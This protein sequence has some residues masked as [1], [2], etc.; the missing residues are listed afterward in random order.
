VLGEEKSY[1]PEQRF[2]IECLINGKNVFAA[3][4]TGFGKTAVILGPEVV[5]ALM[6]NYGVSLV[7]V[8]TVSLMRHMEGKLAKD[9][10]GLAIV[11]V[12]LG[13]DKKI[14]LLQHVL[15]KKAEKNYLVLCSFELF[16]G[17][18]ADLVRAVCPILRITFDEVHQ[19]MEWKD[20]FR[21]CA[22]FEL[23]L[24]HFPSLPC[25]LCSATAP[26]ELRK[27]ICSFL[28]RELVEFQEILH[29]SVRR[30]I[31]FRVVEQTALYCEWPQM[32]GFPL[33]VIVNSFS[34]KVQVRQFLQRALGGESE[35]RDYSGQMPPAE[36]EANQA[37][38]EAN[39]CSGVLIST[40]G[41][42]GTGIDNRRLCHL[43]I[44]GWPR[45]WSALHQYM[46]RVGRQGQNARVFLV[47]KPQDFTKMDT[48]LRVM[49]GRERAVE[50]EA[51]KAR[52]KGPE[53]L[54]TRCT[55]CA[56]HV[57][58]PKKVDGSW[59]RF[60]PEKGGLGEPFVCGAVGWSCSRNC[61][62]RFCI[63]SALV[64]LANDKSPG[65]PLYSNDDCGCNFC[66]PAD[67]A[68]VFRVGDFVQITAWR[69]EYLLQKGVVV[70]CD[71][72]QERFK[73]NFGKGI[74]EKFGG[75]SLVKLAVPVAIPSP[76]PL[77]EDSG[78]PRELHQSLVELRARL[79]LETLELVSLVAS[80]RCLKML[81]RY[82]PQTVAALVDL[83]ALVQIH[84]RFHSAFVNAVLQHQQRKATRV[85]K[86]SKPEKGGRTVDVQLG[87]ESPME[88]PIRK[89]ST[90]TRTPTAKSKAALDFSA[91]FSPV[92]VNTSPIQKGLKSKSK[93]DFSKD[94][95]KDLSFEL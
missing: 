42:Y 60:F 49:L 58:K 54:W 7:V 13:D 3:C 61:R 15:S 80:K 11:S 4:E 76:P 37:W 84:P 94:F 47:E 32:I 17:I 65:D 75:E 38:F 68:P 16:M 19:M 55:Y 18:K 89:K 30:N 71:A 22:A 90:R 34:Q 41:A 31:V 91:E 67:P 6:K 8:P 48:S 35:I 53:K 56:V 74:Y 1:K 23:C 36:K 12:P 40:G 26:R 33:L 92:L 2:A 14:Q 28:G 62:W 86:K 10:P 52:V 87:G 82:R 57:R 24:R 20:D 95:S 51:Q 83:G 70:H 21:D 78:K 9:C 59:L 81:V 66:V 45:T 46:G 85:V 25:L 5:S 29:I 63:P 79:S 77:P 88:S 27:G 44:W 69:S 64:A 43:W 72:G 50:T 93:K 73:I 39:G